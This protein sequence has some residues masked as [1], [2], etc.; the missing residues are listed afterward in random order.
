MRI[1]PLRRVPELGTGHGGTGPPRHRLHVYRYPALRT[2]GYAGNVSVE[3]KDA[4]G[5]FVTLLKESQRQ[6]AIQVRESA[7][8]EF[9]DGAGDYWESVDSA[10]ARL[11][12]LAGDRIPASDFVLTS[13]RSSGGYAH[14]LNFPTRTMPAQRAIGGCPANDL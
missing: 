12:I 2:R 1:P 11:A 7:Y 3:G 8:T 4:L 9:L 6:S 14:V 10:G 5:Q 13:V